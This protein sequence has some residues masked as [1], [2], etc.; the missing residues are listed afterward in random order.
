MSRTLRV[1]LL[2]VVFLGNRSLGGRTFFK[3]VHLGGRSFRVMFKG[4]HF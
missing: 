2:G 3:I 1:V 4:L